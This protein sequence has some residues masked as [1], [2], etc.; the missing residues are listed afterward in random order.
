MDFAN[1]YVLL[2]VSK[3]TTEKVNKFRPELFKQDSPLTYWRGSGGQRYFIL[4]LLTNKV[5]LHFH[6]LNSANKNRV[7]DLT[8]LEIHRCVNPLELSKYKTIAANMSPNIDYWGDTSIKIE[9]VYLNENIWFLIQYK[10]VGESYFVV[11]S[12]AF[13]DFEAYFTRTHK[14]QRFLNDNE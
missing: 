5:I 9:N 7:T 11:N 6:Y 13:I 1:R 10:F 12:K 8:P 4:D 14:I 2:R 3:T